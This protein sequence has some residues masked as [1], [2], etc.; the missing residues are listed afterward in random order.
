LRSQRNLSRFTETA[1][2][3]SPASLGKMYFDLVVQL[4]ELGGVGLRAV[5][6]EEAGVVAVVQGSIRRGFVFHRGA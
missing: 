2:H 6:S 5:G 4:G 3:V 1:T